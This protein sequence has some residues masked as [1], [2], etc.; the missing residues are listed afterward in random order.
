MATYHY[1]SCPVCGQTAKLA[2]LNFDE[3]GNRVAEPAQYGTFLKIQQVGGNPGM[4]WTTLPLPIGMLR[5]L[6]VQLEGAIA[7]VRSQLY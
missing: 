2:Q 4:R 6:L 1:A 5:G 7:F 3:N